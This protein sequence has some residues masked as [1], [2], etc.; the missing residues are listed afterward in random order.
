M[1]AKIKHDRAILGS[2]SFLEDKDMSRRLIRQKVVESL[3]ELE[4][5]PEQL[6]RILAV[7]KH[8]LSTKEFDF[9]QRLIQ[10]ILT[11]QTALDQLITRYLK[12]GWSLSRISILE[13]SILRLAGYEL[14]YERLT[15]PKVVINEA[16][17]LAKQFGDDE[18]KRFINGILGNW[19]RESKTNGD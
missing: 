4:F 15:P 16:I 18:S 7:Q 10:G 9:Y 17:E 1:D 2:G 13:R 6:E 11:N 3:Y 19:I 5:Q 12:Q 8:A 14:Q